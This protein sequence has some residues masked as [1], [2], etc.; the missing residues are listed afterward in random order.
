ML[1]WKALG[2]PEG[3]AS[4][5]LF[6]N[7]PS[8]TLIVEVHAKNR[9]LVPVRLFMRHQEAEVYQP[10]GNPPDD[11]SYKCPVTSTRTPRFFFN[12]DRVVRSER[13]WSGY[14][15]AIYSCDLP[16]QQLTRL[17][18]VRNI[19]LP[20]PFT[21]C[22]VCDLLALSDDEG[23]LYLRLG[24]CEAGQRNIGYYLAS[25]ALDSL[26]IEPLSKLPG[27]FF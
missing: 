13:G 2:I 5:K 18:S 27:V 1:E 22:W 15:D 17:A 16:T 19:A 7:A 6:Y 11:V 23:R 9:E 25:L 14:W 26:A 4:P 8:G 20:K 12:A 3:Y 24:M 21:D 10:V